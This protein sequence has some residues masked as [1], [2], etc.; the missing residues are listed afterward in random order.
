VS[1]EPRQP[2]GSDLGVTVQQHDVVSASR[3]DADIDRCNETQVAAVAHQL[4]AASSRQPIEPGGQLRVRR[5]VVHHDQ[6][7]RWPLGVGQ[8]G[9]DAAASL[10]Q[11]AVY[12][13]DDVHDDT[14]RQGGRCNTAWQ[15]VAYRYR[16][17][18]DP[19]ASEA[20]HEMVE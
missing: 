14:T 9:G 12:R 2:A 15:V 11:A 13:D 7:S 6:A 3:V 18:G 5:A 20:M 16:L 4:D 19:A 8:D 1:A 17:L 10:R